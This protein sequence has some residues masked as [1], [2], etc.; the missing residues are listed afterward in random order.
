MLVCIPMLE[1]S[2]AEN[3]DVILGA[4]SQL[5]PQGPAPKPKVLPLFDAKYCA[6]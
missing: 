3:F 6:G 5:K 1:K 4:L 2:L